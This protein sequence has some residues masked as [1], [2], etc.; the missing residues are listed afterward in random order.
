M[1]PSHGNQPEEM[2]EE[3]RRQHELYLQELMQKNKQSAKRVGK[4]LWCLAMVAW[5]LLL[6]LDVKHHVGPVNILFHGM[7]AVITALIALPTVLDFFA[8]KKKKK[9]I[10]SHEDTEG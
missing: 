10:S 9:D 1:K 4:V 3:E 2:T 8:A 5:A 7:G 6:W